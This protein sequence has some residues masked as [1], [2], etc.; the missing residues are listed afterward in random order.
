MLLPLLLSRLGLESA[1]FLSRYAQVPSPPSHLSTF[2]KS[3]IL[4]GCN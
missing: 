1:P 3:T 4:V 2:M